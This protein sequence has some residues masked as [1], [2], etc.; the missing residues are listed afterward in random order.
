[1]KKLLQYSRLLDDYSQACYL[2]QLGQQVDTS[3]F[4]AEDEYKREILLNMARWVD[5]LLA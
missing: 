4:T 3:R 5:A 2:Q 1:M